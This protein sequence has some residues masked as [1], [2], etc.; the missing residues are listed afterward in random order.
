M[1]RLRY[2]C[3]GFRSGR[4]REVVAVQHGVTDL[5]KAP[6]C[7]SQMVSRVLEPAHPLW[8][9]RKCSENPSPDS[10]SS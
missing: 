1:G 2:R 8:R 10:W 7:S 6:M 3:S 5:T 4:G 9:N